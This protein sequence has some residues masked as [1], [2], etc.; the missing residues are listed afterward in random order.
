MTSAHVP[1]QTGAV[2]GPRVLLAQADFRRVWLTGS[3]G[4]M[5]RWL[6]VLAIGVYTFKLT[7][8]PLA[9]AM[10]MVVRFVPVM[11]FSAFTG[12]FAER[13]NRRLLLLWGLAILSATSF[14][15]AGIAHFGE[16]QIWH[17]G[18]GAFITGLYFTTEFPVRRTMLGEIAGA[19]GTGAA[20]SLDTATNHTMR[21]VG[22][23]TG[24]LIL[25][26]A[27]LQGVYLL[28]GILFACGFVMILRTDYSSGG[29][30]A[31]TLGVLGQIREG[32]SFVLAQPRLIATLS[33][34]MIA[35]MFGFPFAAM[36][37]VIGRDVLVLD[38]FY[39]GTL[40]SAEGAGALLGAFFIATRVRPP[41]FFR[42]YLFGTT[43]FLIGVLCFSLSA[44][45]PLSVAVLFMAGL[46]VAGFSAMQSTIVFTS[47]PP[48]MRSRLMGVLA[49]CIG[50]APFG[51]LHLGLLAN[52]LGAPLALGIIAVEGLLA[53]AVVWFFWLRSRW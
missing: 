48:A 26:L 14:S 50:V 23:P 20:M 2:V 17:I 21:I 18:L 5:M 53:L 32:V 43:L 27:G 28:G 3:I 42:V 25:E 16:I 47:A 9:V 4:W 52:W 33:V 44:L 36:V 30:S 31:S 37:P 34:T 8:S 1:E 12:A 35:N 6:E 19:N 51:M 10:I 22:P 41:Q 13:F 11:L 39:V 7:G 49:V 29:G 38:A 15:L 45:Y 40:Q 46:G 24:G